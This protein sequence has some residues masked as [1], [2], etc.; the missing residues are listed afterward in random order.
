[1]QRNCVGELIKNTQTRTAILSFTLLSVVCLNRLRSFDRTRSFQKTCSICVTQV[2]ATYTFGRFGPIRFNEL[3][4]TLPENTTTQLS[5]SFHRVRLPR[6]FFSNGMRGFLL[7]RQL[8][9]HT[10]NCA[11]S[12]FDLR[13]NVLT[14]TCTSSSQYSRPSAPC[15]NAQRCHF[16]F[17]CRRYACC[18]RRFFWRWALSPL[19]FGSSC[20]FDARSTMMLQRRCF[21]IHELVAR[22]IQ[23][24]FTYSRRRLLSEGQAAI[25]AR[26]DVQN[27]APPPRQMRAFA[28]TRLAVHERRE[29]DYN[30]LSG[31]CIY[32]S[33]S[34]VPANLPGD[35][36]TLS[37]SKYQF[38]YKL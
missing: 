4:Q 35:N 10:S 28:F 19:R 6:L 3:L 14:L 33:R 24:I 5:S 21:L 30:E 11:F 9:S 37:N 16:P 26:F 8:L 31:H 2:S 15:D 20:R 7:K 25:W 13:A 34:A 12:L 32:I 36:C 22:P 17:D 1:M 18:G 29:L 23:D 27:T 38:K